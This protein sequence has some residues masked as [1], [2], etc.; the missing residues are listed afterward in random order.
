MNR[1][2]YFKANVFVCLFCLHFLMQAALVFAK[3]LLEEGPVKPAASSVEKT[4]VPGQGQF[5]PIMVNGRTLTGPNSAALR[6]SGSILIPIM[7]IARVLGDSVTVD[8]ASR[9]ISVRRQTGVAADLDTRLGQL[10]ENGAIVLSVSNTGE[11]VFPLN[12]DE[13]LLPVELAAALFEVAIRYDGAQNV[14][15]VTRGQLPSG[16]ATSRDDRRFAELYQINYDYSLNNYSSASSH[17]LILT[18]AGRLAD[19]RFNFSS[20]SSTTGTHRIS[21]RNLTFNFERPNGQRFVG[22]DFGTGTSLQFMAA[23]VRGGMASIPA[24]SVSFSAFAGRTNSGST[25]PLTPLF[26]D[27]PPISQPIRNTFR[28]DTNV[29]GFYATTNSATRARP[30]I[31]SG[32]VMRFS[33]PSRSGEFVTASTNY[34]GSRFRFQ[35]DAAFGKFAGNG[36]DNNRVNGSGSAFDLSATVQVTDNLSIQG[37][38]SLVGRNFLSPQF[39]LRDPMDLKAAGVTWS[40]KKW[41]SASVNASTMRRPGDASKRDDFVTTAFS[42]TPGGMAPRFY[43]SHTQSSSKEIRSAAFTLFNASK[44]FSRWRLFVNATRV[45]TIG[46]AS[47]NS[48]LGANFRVNDSNAIEVSQGVGSRGNYS[49]QFDWRTSNVLGHRLSFSAGGGYSYSQSSKFTGYERLTAALNLPRQSSL[50]VSYMHTN[51]GPT[52]LVSIRGTLFRK[53]E[54]SAFLNAPASDINSFAKVSGRVYQDTNLNGRYDP[55]VDQ[56]QAD[57]KVRVDGNRYVVSDVNGMFR[58]DSITAGE[59][60]VFLDLLSVRADLTLLDKAAKESTLQAGRDS[61]I[62]FRLV[63]TGRITGRVWLDLNGNG[64][65]D[66]GETP[67]ADVRVVTSSGRD[68]LTDADGYYVIGDLAPGEH[69]ILIDEKTI[70]EKT[71][72]GF[73]PMSMQIYPGRETGDVD[74]PVIMIPAEVKRFGSKP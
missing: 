29:L 46:P 32:G 73:S 44:E 66:G 65:L 23:N 27:E 28:F 25:L 48:Q 31:F 34:G 61:T 21:P 22:G 13:L 7:A 6:R 1:T 14:M 18:A 15:L 40:P 67:L 5:V 37:R 45:K 19:G 69:V 39:G 36:V 35:A 52:L 50:Q 60:K 56:P 57:V 53:R 2:A 51:A 58:F 12:P 74:L 4:D 62:D 55:G 70:P 30:L 63:R 43:L 17:N 68:T 20:N 16:T 24:G 72:S 9:S 10:R 47:Y 11:L 3:P 49:G 59:H 64:K 54:A 41:L 8:A 33:G 42:L 26:V 71:K 38:Y